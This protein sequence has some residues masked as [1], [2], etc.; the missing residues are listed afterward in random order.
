MVY[1]HFFYLSTTIVPITPIRFLFHYAVSI[2]KS[3]LPPHFD[4]FYLF[5]SFSIIIR[6]SVCKEKVEKMLKDVE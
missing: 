6:G 4:P 1:V 3:S 2:V 5:I